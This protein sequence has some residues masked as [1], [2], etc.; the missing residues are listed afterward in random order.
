MAKAGERQMPMVE[1]VQG[2]TLNGRYEA[3][4]GHRSQLTPGRGR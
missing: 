4:V 3:E 1:I 2:K